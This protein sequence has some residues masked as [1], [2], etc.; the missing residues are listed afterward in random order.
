MKQISDLVKRIPVRN[1]PIKNETQPRKELPVESDRS[2]PIDPLVNTPALSPVEKEEEKEFSPNFS[3]EEEVDTAKLDDGPGWKE[4]GILTAVRIRPLNAPEVIN[5]SR[6]V[7]SNPE[8]MSQGL[9]IIN[10]IFFKSSTQTDKL[11]KLEERGFS[12]DY[13]FWSLAPGSGVDQDE[14]ASQRDI[15]YKIGKPIIQN[16]LTGFNS[17]LFAYGA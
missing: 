11:R 1:T 14:Y 16:A 3:L 12:F 9:Q 5:N 2:A 7:V 4:G 6:I 15:Y 13:T 17:S 10:P 8:F